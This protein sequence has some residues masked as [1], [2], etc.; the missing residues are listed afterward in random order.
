MY[1]SSLEYFLFPPLTIKRTSFFSEGKIF[2]RNDIRK[3]SIIKNFLE[4]IDTD[5]KLKNSNI[6]NC[7]Y[8]LNIKSKP[9]DDI[10]DG[11]WTLLTLKKHYKD[12]RETKQS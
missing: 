9:V 8:D 7:I 10:V 11:F 5:E 2:R 6:C 4:Y 1:K 3:E 12:G